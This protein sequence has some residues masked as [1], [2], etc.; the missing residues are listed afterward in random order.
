MAVGLVLDVGDVVGR[1][2]NGAEGGGI[3]KKALKR[4]E[5]E[6][7]RVKTEEKAERDESCLCSWC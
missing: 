5:G 1:K 2:E 7:G 3:W 6:E 4:E